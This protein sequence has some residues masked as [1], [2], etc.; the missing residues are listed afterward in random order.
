MPGYMEGRLHEYS[1][2]NGSLTIFE[3]ADCASTF[4]LL[5]IGG[6]TEVSASLAAAVDNPGVHGYSLCST[7]LLG[8]EHNQMEFLSTSYEE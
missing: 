5:F 7:A 2:S 8:A 6:L 1:V 3:S 4:V